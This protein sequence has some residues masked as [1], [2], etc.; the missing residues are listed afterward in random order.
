M[1]E[2]LLIFHDWMKRSKT[3][4]MNSRLENKYLRRVKALVDDIKSCF[5][6]EAGNGW[7]IQKLHETM[8]VV[9]DI[10]RFGVAPNF[11]AGIGESL[12]QHF[13]KHPG[14]TTK[15][16]AQIQFQESIAI[17]HRGYETQAHLRMTN[18]IGDHND[19]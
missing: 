5:P 13:A 4:P 18:M 1:M 17:R 2:D 7:N 3:L 12:L 10:S 11:D 8:H 19:A 6:R 15:Y 14:S 16:V 9:R